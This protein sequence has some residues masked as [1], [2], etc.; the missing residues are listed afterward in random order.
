MGKVLSS[1][2]P[3]ETLPS[4]YPPIEEEGISLSLGR[5]VAASCLGSKILATLSAGSS[6]SPKTSMSVM[7]ATSRVRYL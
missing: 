5:A 7:R 3:C 1:L 4:D 2:V 6:C